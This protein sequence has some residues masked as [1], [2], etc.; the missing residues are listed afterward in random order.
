MN[1]NLV[2]AVLQGGALVI[3]GYHLL[4]GLPRMQEQAWTAA[5][6]LLEAVLVDKEAEARR[7]S[8]QA[9]HL[10][11]AVDR[12]TANGPSVCQYPRQRPPS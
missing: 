5:R 1:E 8:G 3:L 6:S 7:L 12:L 2:Q 11:A 10:V 4:W 9:D